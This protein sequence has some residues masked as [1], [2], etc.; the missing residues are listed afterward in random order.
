MYIYI[1]TYICIYVFGACVIL[2]V[3]EWLDLCLIYLDLMCLQFPAKINPSEKRA[4]C[5]G[6][7]DL[8]FLHIRSYMAKVTATMVVV[9]GSL[10]FASLTYEVGRAGRDEKVTIHTDSCMKLVIVCC[11]NGSTFEVWK[12]IVVIFDLLAQGDRRI[13]LYIFSVIPMQKKL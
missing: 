10:Y 12:Q 9:H 8:M 1:Y 6:W 11:L 3:C 13:L 2:E 7:N 4:F 5:G